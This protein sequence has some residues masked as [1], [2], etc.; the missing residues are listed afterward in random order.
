[1]RESDRG[2][3]SCSGKSRT[4]YGVKCRML[5]RRSYVVLV[6]DSLPADRH[7]KGSIG[8]PGS[9]LLRIGTRVLPANLTDAFLQA[10]VAEGVTTLGNPIYSPTSKTKKTKLVQT[11]IELCDKSVGGITE[12]YPSF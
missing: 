5:P 11:E 10:R 8:T 1:M 9:P 4:E 2:Q 7:Y 12:C 6:L 3:I